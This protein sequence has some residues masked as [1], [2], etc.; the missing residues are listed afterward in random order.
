M[1]KL[2]VL[3]CIAGLLAAQTPTQN[4]PQQSDAS[5][6]PIV[7]EHREVLVPVTVQ[8]QS[9]NSVRDL[10]PY[11]FRLFDN[12]KAQKITQDMAQH[13][14]SVVVVIQANNDVGMFLPK[15]VKQASAL[16]SLVVG[17]GGEVA[18]IAFDHRFQQLTGFT[19]DDAQID[20][21]FRKLCVEP[22]SSRLCT[23]K[24]GSYTAQLNDAAM[25]GINLLKTRPPGRRRV[26]LLISENRDKGSSTKAREVLTEAEF[27]N[28][29]MYSLD[30]SQLLDALSS[31]AQP[32][33]PDPRPPGAVFLGGG[34]T[35]TP[36]TQSQMNMGNWVPALKDIFLA[37]K[38]VFVHDP[39]DV[40][41]QYTGG[42]ECGFKDD[43]ALE[44]CVAQIGDELHSQY[45]LS[46]SPNN[47]SEGGFHQI[48]VEVLK[49]GL[50]VRT[51][52]GYWT[53]GKPE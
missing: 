43:K 40:F 19:S 2:F 13:P 30:I 12:G 27:N 21:A 8:D 31:K 44:R 49:P 41:T 7:V 35:D 32:N 39:L 17:S 52:E 47:P 22:A 1:P 45:L 38:G 36:T 28:V 18:V 33:R 24:T 26:M 42:R 20:A 51:R 5:D 23:A 9:H 48:R 11:D 16:E 15:I 34:N 14:L 25:E 10:T 6:K 4:P 46:Y 50:T 53:A 37:A 3:T 29:V